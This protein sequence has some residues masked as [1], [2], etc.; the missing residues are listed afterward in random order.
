[1]NVELRQK[2]VAYMSVRDLSTKS[3]FCTWWFKY[4]LDGFH[5][6][7]VIRKELNDMEKE[8]IVEVN[9]D[10]KNNHMWRLTGKVSV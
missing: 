2:I 6:T 1:M 4:H 10:Q 8:G 5:V 7:K 3:W 9:R